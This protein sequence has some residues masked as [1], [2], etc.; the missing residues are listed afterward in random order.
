MWGEPIMIEAPNGET[1]AV[2]LVGTTRLIFWPRSLSEMSPFFP[3]FL[4]MKKKHEIDFFL[5]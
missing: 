1:F 5:Q 3:S 4:L 2:A